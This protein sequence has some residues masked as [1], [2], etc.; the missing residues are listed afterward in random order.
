VI[1]TQCPGTA[2]CPRSRR[3]CETWE[4]LD[5]QMFVGVTARRGGSAWAGGQPLPR[6]KCPGAPSFAFFAKGGIPRT[7]T[8][9][10][11]DFPW[12]KTG[13]FP[14]FGESER[15]VPRISRFRDAGL[16]GWHDSIRCVCGFGPGP[17]FRKPR[18]VGH[19]KIQTDCSF[20]KLYFRLKGRAPGYHPVGG[21]S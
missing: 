7:S 9:W 14:V 1:E 3:F 4:R 17:T 18:K 8:S 12:G 21:A 5:P 15:R 10:V 6:R 19:P 20:R 16:K 11:F 13:R 2:G